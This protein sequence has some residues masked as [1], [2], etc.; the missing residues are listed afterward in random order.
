MGQGSL[1]QTPRSPTATLLHVVIFTPNIT[2]SKHTLI[3]VYINFLTN[4][5][6]HLPN[7]PSL[8]SPLTPFIDNSIYLVEIEFTKRKRERESCF[9]RDGGRRKGLL[10]AGRLQAQHQQGLL[11]RHRRQGNHHHHHRLPD[12]HLFKPVCSI[13]GQLAD[14]REKKLDW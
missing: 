2:N 8:S 9:K 3:L 1:A 13:Y 4:P 11:A 6:T 12:L 10:I 14:H 5:P 7:S